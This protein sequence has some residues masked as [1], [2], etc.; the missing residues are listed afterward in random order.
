MIMDPRLM[1]IF[2]GIFVISLDI[3]FSSFHFHHSKDQILDVELE[4]THGFSGGI[5]HYYHF[6]M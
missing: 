1:D 2:Y 4:Q 5:F 3:F 6:E